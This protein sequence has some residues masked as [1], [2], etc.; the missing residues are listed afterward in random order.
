MNK[1]RLF[2][3]LRVKWNTSGSKI[4][5]QINRLK[6]NSDN[7][8]T[9]GNRALISLLLCS[10]C[11]LFSFNSGIGPIP[12]S[13]ADAVAAQAVNKAAIEQVIHDYLLK[14]PE[15]LAEA[16]AALQVKQEAEAKLGQTKFIASSA[17]Q[18]FESPNDAII[19]NPKGD[20]TV[21]EFFD[22]N[23]G[24]CRRAINDMN[25]LVKSDVNVRFVL[26]E[27]PILGPDSVKAHFIAQAFRKM[28]PEKYGDY[29]RALLGSGHADE[30][31]AVALAVS[32]G[33]DETKL[34]EASKDPSISK[35][36]EENNILAGGLNIT[37]TPSYVIKDF[38]VPGAMGLDTL[39]EKVA[40]VRK[41]N[42]ATC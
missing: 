3:Q 22:Y 31:S 37:G 27:L 40:N 17:T 28:M 42:S 18:I 13:A 6:C 5:Q 20:V 21:V 11:L 10:G 15:I 12:A 29:H 8:K 41:C 35:I 1:N 4:M 2:E 9:R 38:V 14:N 26:K 33:A 19:G 7:I 36:F 24:Y 16:Q 32:M 25:E 39:I 23:C 30:D 34:R